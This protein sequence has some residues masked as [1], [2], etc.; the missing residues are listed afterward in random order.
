MS[1]FTHCSGCCINAGMHRARDRRERI[2]AA[3]LAGIMA[4]SGTRLDLWDEKQRA[5]VGDGAVRLADALIAAL[6]AEP[7]DGD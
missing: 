3:V 5:E 7:T 2:A 1:N 4:N 6:D